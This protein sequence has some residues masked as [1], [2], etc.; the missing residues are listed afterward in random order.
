MKALCQK[1]TILTINDLPLKQPQNCSHMVQIVSGFDT[2]LP[3]KFF[4]KRSSSNY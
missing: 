1:L 4:L 2:V 3:D